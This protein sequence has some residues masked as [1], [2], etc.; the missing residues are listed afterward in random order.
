M[1]SVK[2]RHEVCLSPVVYFLLWEL[3]F[4]EAGACFKRE[5][6]GSGLQWAE[7]YNNLINCTNIRGGVKG[8]RKENMK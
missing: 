8:E 1:A 5:V 6:S 3:Q 2:H 7:Q 4:E